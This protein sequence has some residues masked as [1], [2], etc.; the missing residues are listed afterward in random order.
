MLEGQSLSNAP[1][2]RQWC[3]FAQCVTFRNQASNL[4]VLY[5]FPLEVAGPS[6]YNRQG[7]NDNGSPAPYPSNCQHVPASQHDLSMAQQFCAAPITTLGDVVKQHV[8][9]AY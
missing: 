7:N 2:F 4:I 3:T 9:H 6:S 5:S 1:S 8:P